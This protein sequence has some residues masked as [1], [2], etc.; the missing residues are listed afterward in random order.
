MKTRT[1]HIVSSFVDY[2]GLEHKF[3]VA[4][5]SKVLP[6]TLGESGLICQN[7]DKDLELSHEV[8]WYTDWDSDFV[9]NVVKSLSIGVAICNP[10][11]EFNEAIGL[12]KAIAK[13]RPAM[14]ATHSGYVSARLVKAL[15]EQ[16]AY[17]VKTN[18]GK[19]IKGYNEAEKKY[20]VEKKLKDAYDILSFDQKLNIKTMKHLEET[21]NM[22]EVRK[23]YKYVDCD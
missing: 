3:V 18:P 12:K 1:D 20:L 4:A 19:Y 23:M 17:Y 21:M 13:S 15:L 10:E 14:Y 16:E 22:E 6:T 5:T 9:D 8:T 2:K 7:E 11:D